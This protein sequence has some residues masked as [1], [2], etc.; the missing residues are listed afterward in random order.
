MHKRSRERQA[1]GEI[2]KEREKRNTPSSFFTHKP[3]NV[4]WAKQQTR[5]IVL[6]VVA[7]CKNRREQLEN[8]CVCA[9]LHSNI[10]WQQ[11]LQASTI[12]M[13]ASNVGFRRVRLH[14]SPSYFSFLFH[15]FFPFVSFASFYGYM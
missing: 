5:R 1:T 4:R 7:S 15:L 12:Y 3:L 11:C 13:H 9:S 2:Q 6:L 10:C 8:I 14:A